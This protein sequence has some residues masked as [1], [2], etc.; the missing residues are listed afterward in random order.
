MPWRNIML[1]KQ[2]HLS[3][4]S[5]T[6]RENNFTWLHDTMTNFVEK[7]L[8]ENWTLWI[9]RNNLKV[10]LPV[11]VRN[12]F[13]NYSLALSRPGEIRPRDGF[14]L[15]CPETV[16]NRKQKLCYFYYIQIS[17]HSGISH[18]RGTSTVTMAMLLLK[19]SWLK[20]VKIAFFWLNLCPVSIL[21]YFIN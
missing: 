8:Q 11:P 2:L 3:V 16:S 1:H 12:C 17:F 13:C 10:T 20:S 15:C 7:L 4:V 19:S 5:V 6:V 18:F 14:S 9:A 21:A